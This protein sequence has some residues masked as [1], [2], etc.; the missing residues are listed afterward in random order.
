[1]GEM[2]IKNK[3]WINKERY[4]ELKHFCLQYDLWKEERTNLPL[5]SSI[6]YGVKPSKNDIFNPT[7]R[8]AFWLK[9]YSDR[10]QMIEESAARADKEMSKYLVMAVTKNWSYDILKARTN[11]PYCRNTYYA[12]YRK[13]FWILNKIRE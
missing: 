9:Y 6:H 3:Y 8:D 4:Y 1:M 12:A 10:I 7:E 5:F 13:F 11:I 2:S